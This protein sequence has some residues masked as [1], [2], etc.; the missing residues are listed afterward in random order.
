[1]GKYKLDIGNA[2][3]GKQL[4]PVEFE[5]RIQEEA[6]AKSYR[7]LLDAAIN[8]ADGEYIGKLF[9]QTP[10]L[11]AWEEVPA[12]VISCVVSSGNVVLTVQRVRYSRECDLIQ[13]LHGICAHLNQLKQQ[14][15]LSLLS[16]KPLPPTE[17]LTVLAQTK[18][19]LEILFAD[20]RPEYLDRSQLVDMK[21]KIIAASE[22]IETAYKT[23]ANSF[24]VQDYSTTVAAE[25]SSIQ[26]MLLGFLKNNNL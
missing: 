20:Y 10:I 9:K 24:F 18:N 25:V 21:E 2:V 7:I 15:A 5:E 12:P 8:F 6:K 22:T 17:A 1:M 16:S 11:H 4:S 19:I 26:V 3:T 13:S 14:F 23:Y